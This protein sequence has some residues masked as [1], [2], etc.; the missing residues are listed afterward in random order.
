MEA[1]AEQA[2]LDGLG[3]IL[4]EVDE[5]ASSVAHG[6]ASEAWSAT[7]DGEGEI[8]TEPTFA[9]LGSAADDSDAGAR[10]ERLD[11]PLSLGV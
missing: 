11:E 3:W 5:H 6:E 4:G 10:P 9:G 8:E 7:G 2:L 1:E